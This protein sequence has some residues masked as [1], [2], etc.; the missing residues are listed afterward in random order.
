[1]AVDIVLGR[2]RQESVPHCIYNSHWCF[3]ALLNDAGCKRAVDGSGG[4]AV[5]HRWE[6]AAT[7]EINGLS[8]MTEKGN[9]IRSFHG[10]K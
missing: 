5:A 6:A 1:V 2:F 10:K 3:G 7:L 8:K 4:E 9:E